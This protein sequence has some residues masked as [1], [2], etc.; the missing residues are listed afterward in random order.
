MCGVCC[1]DVCSI[2]CGEAVS[3]ATCGES[4]FTFFL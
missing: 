1:G 4:I 2:S 3:K